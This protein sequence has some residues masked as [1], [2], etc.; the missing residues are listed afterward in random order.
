[1]TIFAKVNQQAIIWVKEMMAELRTADASMALHALRAGLHALR[2]RLTVD[3]AAQLSAQLPLLVRGIFFEGWD[4]TGKPLRIRHRAEF[5]AL[6]HEKYQ[7]RDDLAADDIM[8]ALFRL[9]ARHVST[10]ELN[11]II[12][13]L[14]QEI[15]G[16]VDGGGR[17]DD[18]STDR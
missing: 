13:S 16:V 1:M 2:D 5:L 11:D 4:P 12:F 10:G 14:P 7:P 6:V 9:L 18:Q 3:E 8:L 15:A 17:R